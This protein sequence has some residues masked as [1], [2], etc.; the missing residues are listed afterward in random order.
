MRQRLNINFLTGDLTRFGVTAAAMVDTAISISHSRLASYINIG[1][2]AQLLRD[3]ET[4][5]RVS[6]AIRGLPL[7]QASSIGDYYGALSLNRQGPSAFP[8]S[9]KIL[10]E[11]ANRGPQ[12]F[13]AKARVALGTNFRISGDSDASMSALR[14]V[15]ETAGGQPGC[16]HPMYLAQLQW[17]IMRMAECNHGAAIDR[18]QAMRPLAISLGVEYPSVLPVYYNNLAHVL[19]ETGRLSEAAPLCAALAKSPFLPAY[20]ELRG[21]LK[22]FAAKSRAGS[23]SVCVIGEPLPENRFALP[24]A[25]PRILP[26]TGRFAEKTRKARVIRLSAWKAKRDKQ[27]PQP[28]IAL[29]TEQI[30]TMSTQQKQATI[31][32]LILEDDITDQELD[33]ILEVVRTNLVPSRR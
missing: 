15:A 9:N 13:R 8:E 22:M 17:V 20:P 14:E 11:V 31:L 28:R 2:K 10:M 25:E 18:L 12:L 4:L 23:R 5:N 30:R 32:K 26:A 7:Q 29:T 1:E 6:R 19:I 33:Q 21:T 24:H 16:L 3:G 27:L